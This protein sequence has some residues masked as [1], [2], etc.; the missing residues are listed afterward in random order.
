VGDPIW[1]VVGDDAQLLLHCPRDRYVGESR[2]L[3]LSSDAAHGFAELAFVG[4]D[5]Q[6]M[7]EFLEDTIHFYAPIKS[8]SWLSLS[9]SAPDTQEMGSD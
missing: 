8:V 2:N 5:V 7:Q 4:G 6:S 3:E 9:M 1:R